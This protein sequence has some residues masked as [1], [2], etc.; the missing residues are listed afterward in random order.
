MLILSDRNIKKSKYLTYLG[1]YSISICIQRFTSLCFFT[2]GLG[3]VLKTK[4]KNGW[5]Y[6]SRLTGWAQKGGQNPTKKNYFQKK[7]K[8]DQNI[9]IHPEN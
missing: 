8:D 4:T 1:E 7:Y 5:I 6:P 3:K 9:L 2:Y